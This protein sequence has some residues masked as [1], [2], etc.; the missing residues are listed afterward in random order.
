MQQEFNQVELLLREQAE[1]AYSL[2]AWVAETPSVVEAFAARDREKLQ[3]LLLPTFEKLKN[4]LN[5]SQFQ[6]H[7]PPATSFLRLHKPSKFGDDLTSLR[8][9]IVQVNST[10]KPVMG[11]DKGRFGIGIR[12]LVPVFS[13][14]KH[15]GSVEFGM[16]LND[17]LISAL[18]KDFGYDVSILV[19][20]DDTFEFQAKTHN[21]HVA[22]K[23]VPVLKE[24]FKSGKAQVRRVNKESKKLLTFYFPLVDYS[25]EIIGIVAIPTDITK[26]ISRLHWHMVYIS[27]A[28]LVAIL[29]MIFF[30]NMLIDKFVKRPLD[31]VLEFIKGVQKGNYSI[32]LTQKFHCEMIPL[33]SGLNTMTQA[34]EESMEISDRE[35]QKA[36]SAAEKAQE[37]LEQASEKESKLRGLMDA[38]HD[39]A[40]DA[41]NI[42]G[43]VGAA[44]DKLT[45]MFT[46]VSSGTEHQ[47]VRV[48]E[49]A[50]AMEQMNASVVEVTRNA[51][52]SADDSRQAMDKAFSGEEVVGKAVN[53]I[54]QVNTIADNLR[55]QMEELNAATG[56]I[57]EVINV[58]NEIADQTNL[59]ALNAAIEAARAGEYGR[60][61]A[62]VADE[63]RKL[64]EK[65]MTATKEVE[66]KIGGIQEMTKSNQDMTIRAAEA[67]MQATS[68]A[69]DSGEALRDIVVHVRRTSDEVGSIATA[70]E[71]QL[72]ASEQITEAMGEINS[73]ADVVTEKMQLSCL[74]VQELS[75][76][77]HRL[78]KLVQQ[79][80]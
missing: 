37:A 61:F 48:T 71:Q 49:V 46:E 58:I 36:A 12:G 16:A 47:R 74:E 7:L 57:G 32:R 60:G 34:V 39:L 2:A 63:V 64:A 77:V 45:S 19:P 66:Q 28:A 35:K 14:G 11:L 20:K 69:G 33:S 78:Q 41:K 56:S 22:P 10:Q 70:S 13:Q 9:T 44:T 73:I 75:D 40:A 5:L 27:C 51:T 43:S 31:Q 18:K 4:D 17:A 65:T 50:A 72:A 68:L 30:V 59:L 24:I 6:F 3:A 23:M 26:D 79:L 25:G 29:I 21:M 80:V 55:K 52:S 62:V 67:V 54:S 8:P 42:T 53:A 38:M 1:T 15:I 76:L